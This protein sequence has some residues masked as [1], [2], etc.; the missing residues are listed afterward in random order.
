MGT[1]LVI[2]CEIRQ[3]MRLLSCHLQINNAVIVKVAVA[4]ISISYLLLRP[5]NRNLSAGYL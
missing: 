1:I 3:M 5:T 2:L 4:A